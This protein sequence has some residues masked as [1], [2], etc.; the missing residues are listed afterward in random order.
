MNR[1]RALTLCLLASLAYACGPGLSDSSSGRDD[2]GGSDDARDAWVGTYTTNY[3]PKFG[4]GIEHLEYLLLS[5]GTAERRKVNCAGRDFAP[6]YSFLWR[7]VDD[8]TVEIFED[9]VG[10]EHTLLALLTI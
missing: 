2:G 6:N 3:A 5:D 9:G 1:S 7:V 10:V 4:A 8:T